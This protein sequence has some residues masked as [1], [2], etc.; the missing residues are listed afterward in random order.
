MKSHFLTSFSQAPTRNSPIS[1]FMFRSYN[2]L[3]II[4]EFYLPEVK[5]SDNLVV[6]RATERRQPTSFNSRS[7]P[8]QLSAIIRKQDIPL[9]MGQTSRFSWTASRDLWT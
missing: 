6:Y 5:P 7:C 8:N 2:S 3:R 4:I 9:F 1:V